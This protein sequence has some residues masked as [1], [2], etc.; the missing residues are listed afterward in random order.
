MGDKSGLCL[1]CGRWTELRALDGQ[2]DCDRYECMQKRRYEDEF[3]FAGGVRWYP[4]G[5]ITPA[6]LV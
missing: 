6:P 1:W 3:D 4:S 5:E 2:A